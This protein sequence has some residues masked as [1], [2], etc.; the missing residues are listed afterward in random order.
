MVETDVNLLEIQFLA[1]CDLIDISLE[2]LFEF[3]SVAVF[4]QKD[5][6]VRKKKFNQYLIQAVFCT[7]EK[8][9]YSV[10]CNLYHRTEVPFDALDVLL[11][12]IVLFIL[13]KELIKR[14]L[15]AV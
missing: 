4:L 1:E 14:A 10:K 6:I 12:G 5:Q 2:T 8:S 11:V 9:A 3:F 13:L 15:S 7:F